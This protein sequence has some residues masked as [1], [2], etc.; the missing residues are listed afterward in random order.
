MH[1]R[2][3]C[4]WTTVHANLVLPVTGSGCP[5]V[6]QLMIFETL[7]PQLHLDQ[8]IPE[9]AQLCRLMTHVG[10][11]RRSPQYL[12]WKKVTFLHFCSS[13]G[14][15]MRLINRKRQHFCT[16]AINSFRWVPLLFL[17]L[18]ARRR[19]KNAV[20]FHA[21]WV[22]PLL[23]HFLKQGGTQ[24]NELISKKN[25]LRFFD[26]SR[27]NRTHFSFKN[28]GLNAKGADSFYIFTIGIWK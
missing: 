27:K 19:L 6:L 26:V 17:L 10:N 13:A 11:P 7:A 8:I 1:E 15:E 3:G 25:Q 22:P 2:N 9:E 12:I 24:R 21:T 18:G 28:C 4:T 23:L 5:W 14:I 16:K 20:F